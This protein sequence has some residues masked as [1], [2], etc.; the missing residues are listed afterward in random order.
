MAS[1]Y[2]MKA[3]APNKVVIQMSTA[4]GWIDVETVK[5]VFDGVERIKELKAKEDWVCQIY[6]EVGNLVGSASAS[7]QPLDHA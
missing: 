4:S 6:D 2:Q 1:T 5:N 3:T 7:H